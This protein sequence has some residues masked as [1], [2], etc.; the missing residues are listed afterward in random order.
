MKQA[1]TAILSVFL[2]SL[3]L[4]QVDNTKQIDKGSTKDWASHWQ[5]IEWE[6]FTDTFDVELVVFHYPKKKKVK[7]VRNA[8]LIQTGEQRG[9]RLYGQRNVT[10]W[11]VRKPWKRKI[12]TILIQQG[13]QYNF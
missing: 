4:G 2:A 12:K 5:Q 3:L 13:D 7:A 1:I 6:H 11:V 8:T 10:T 9:K